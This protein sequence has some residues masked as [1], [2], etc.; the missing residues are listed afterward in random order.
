MK[1]ISITIDPLGNPKIEASGFTGGACK[2]A[3]KPLEDIFAGGASN[4]VNKPEMMQGMMA[5]VQQ[6]G[7]QRIGG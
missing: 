5:P 2:L 7:T 4:T 3:T 1:T 6:Q